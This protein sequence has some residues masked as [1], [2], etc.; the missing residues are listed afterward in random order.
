MLKSSLSTLGTLLKLNP[1]IHS[2]ADTNSIDLIFRQRRHSID[3]L[4]AFLLASRM[5]PHCSIAVNYFATGTPG[6]ERFPA[7]A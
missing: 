5:E 2:A 1:S 6:K 7:H 3:S 4:K